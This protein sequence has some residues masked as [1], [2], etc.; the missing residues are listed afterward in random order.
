MTERG[1]CPVFPVKSGVPIVGLGFLIVAMAVAMAVT[2]DRAAHPLVLVALFAVFGLF[3][4][5]LG[6]TK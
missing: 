5:W 2:G 3:L 4:V 6:C 1:A